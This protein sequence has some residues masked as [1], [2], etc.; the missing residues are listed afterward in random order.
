MFGLG[1][2]ELLFL[3]ALIVAFL[4]VRHFGRGSAR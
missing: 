3:A 1:V 4:L 2:P